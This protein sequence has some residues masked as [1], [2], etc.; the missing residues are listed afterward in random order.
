MKLYGL[1]AVALFSLV[2]QLSFLPAL[3][4]FGVVPNIVLI[5]IAA[6]ALSGPLVTAMI[7][8]MVCGFL[9]DLVSGSDFGLNTGLLAFGVI[10]AA[11]VS[12][13]GLQL[14]IRVQL[15]FVILGVTTV[16]AIIGIL[17]LL[18]SGGRI[19]IGTAIFQSITIL[20]LNC[21]LGV[22]VGPACAWLAKQNELYGG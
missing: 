4:P 17:G 3:R 14:G 6:A 20:I 7:L 22:I 1:I 18:I 19:S 12:R 5:V 2:L 11:Y 15:L 21:S 13:S 9:L 10:I 16:T 8:G